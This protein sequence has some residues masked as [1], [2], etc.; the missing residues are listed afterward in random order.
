MLPCNCGG[1]PLA[2]SSLTNKNKRGNDCSGNRNCKSE[3]M[4]A[5]K[6]LIERQR[7]KCAGNM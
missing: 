5:R 6:R 3:S 2:G 4:G 7:P 1:V